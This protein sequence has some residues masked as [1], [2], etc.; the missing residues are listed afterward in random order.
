MPQ[1]FTLTAEQ[2]EAFGREG[3]L[4]L[5]GFYPADLVNPMADAIW[6][7]ARQRFGVERDRPETWPPT[8]IGQHAKL[9]KRGVFDPLGTAQLRALGDAFLGAGTWDP[10]R[11]WGQPL[12]VSF[13]AGKWDVPHNVWH[14]DLPAADYTEALPMIRFFAF[15]APV[16][17]RGGGTPYIE[18][19]HLAVMDRARA[20]GPGETLRSA[21]LRKALEREEPW[22]ADL[23]KP[24][25]ED[26]VAQFMRKSGVMR[27]FPVRVGEM[28]GEPGDLIVM[29]PAMI[30]SVA[31]NA[32]D[33][34]RLV[35]AITLYTRDALQ[36][37]PDEA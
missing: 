32:L 10:P 33:Q 1:T 22:L 23:L 20:A 6:E 28:T 30:H 21:E 16:R 18:G 37:M 4:R 12:L 2:R 24:G 15:L 35:G 7:D 27:G 13:P 5:P 11:H 25:G 3:V 36:G 17:P 29:H 8:R 34:P 31:N 19:S 9:R 14:L 26:R